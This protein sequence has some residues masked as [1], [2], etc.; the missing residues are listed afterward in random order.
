MEEVAKAVGEKEVWKRMEKI[1]DRWRQPEAGL[2]H[3]YGQ[4]K[5]AARELWIR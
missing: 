3:L 5:K 2:L 4:K 1:K